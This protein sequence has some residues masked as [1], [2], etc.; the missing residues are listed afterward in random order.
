MESRKIA[1]FTSEI[2]S[3][4]DYVRPIFGPVVALCS[5]YSRLLREEDTR[6]R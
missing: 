5:L 4:G 3:L 1:L 2:Y 6:G